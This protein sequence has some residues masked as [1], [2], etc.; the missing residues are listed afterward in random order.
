MAAVVWVW[1]WGPAARQPATNPGLPP[2]TA[3]ITKTTLKETRTLTGTLGYSDPAPVTATIPG[4]LTWIAP[5]GSTVERGDPLFE[6]AGRPVVVLYGSSPL[7][8]TLRDDVAI[9]EPQVKVARARAALRDAEDALVTAKTQSSLELAQAEAKVADARVAV[10]KAQEALDA[11]K[12]SPSKAQD[13]VDSARISLANAEG[14]LKLTRKGWDGKTDAAKEAFGKALGGYRGVFKKWLG[15]DLS[16][17]DADKDPESLLDS[18]DVDLDEIFKRPGRYSDLGRF[19]QTQGAPSDDPSTRWNETT[20]YTWLNFYIGTIAPTCE[21]GVIPAQGACVQ[22][23]MDDAWSAYR[24]ARDSLDAA[25]IQGAKAI[26]DAGSA[27]TRARQNLTV[28]E[29]EFAA[30]EMGPDPLEKD[31]AEKQ[32]ALAQASLGVAEGDLSKLKGGPDPLKVALMESEVAAARVALENAITQLDAATRDSVLSGADVQQLQR[33]LAELG[34]T[35]FTVDGTYTPA[36]AKAVRAWQA[37]L[38][39]PVTGMVEAGQVIFTPGPIRIA[40]HSASV[41][42]TIRDG[43]VLT[44]TDTTGLVTVELDPARQSQVKRGDAVTITLPNLKTTPG[45]VSKVGTVATTPST[46]GQSGANRPTI[47]VKIILT[48]PAAADG[49]DQAPV[50]VSITTATAANALAVPVTAL[51]ALAGGGYAVEV[52]DPDG[53]RRLEAV[54]LGIFDDAGGLVQVTGPGL[55]PGQRVVVPAT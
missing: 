34:Y 18:W 33:N 25:E 14:D 42:N 46:G 9:A 28:A 45:T 15:I 43:A 13:A 7:Y 40:E 12:K 41:G 21:D 3:R 23:E 2:A 16:E 1:A 48:D 17:S 6:V 22:R 53:G 51:L 52:V 27:V 38:G 55:A 4:T 54:T 35:G 10:K 20:V 36:T 29:E 5:V 50:L 11:L 37:D 24:Q 8:R 30:L 31:Q 26:S 32:L 19:T 44:Y 47:P 39:L 49:L